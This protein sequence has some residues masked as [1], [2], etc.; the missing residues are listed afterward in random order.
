MFRRLTNALSFRA[1]LLATLPIRSR[2][3]RQVRE[4]DASG[5]ALI[6]NNCL[7]GQLY[8]M[9]GRPKATP[10]AGLYFIGDSYGHFLD[11]LADG[12]ADAWSSID[13]GQLTIYGPQNCAMLRTGDEAGIVFLHYPDPKVAARK[14]NDRF[15]RLEGRERVVIASLRDGIEERMLN[16]AKSQYR[17]LFIAGPAPAPP[18]DEFALD[19][20]WL[21]QLAQFFDRVLATKRAVTRS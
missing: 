15:P 4:L 16:R 18:A 8:E 9:A 1:R 2:L 11:D 20:R 13:P 6:S 19:R 17:H 7:A 10:T 5:F 12:K 14:W 3:G 21:K